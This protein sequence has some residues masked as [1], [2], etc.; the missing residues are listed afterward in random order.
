[1]NEQD[2]LRHLLEIEAQSLSLVTDA[3]AEA[4]RRVMEA[5]NRNRSLYEARYA[6]ETAAL[7]ERCGKELAA[8][9]EDYQQRLENYRQSLAE[10]MP[11]DKDAFCSLVN[12]CLAGDC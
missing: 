5:E 3:Q 12:A 11:V 9:K 6:A 4:D 8:I 1:M 10:S 7:D 2:I